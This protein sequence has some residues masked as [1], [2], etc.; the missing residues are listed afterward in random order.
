MY[1]Q[2]ARLQFLTHIHTDTSQHSIFEYL[3]LICQLGMK[4]LYAQVSV[5]HFSNV[6]F[7]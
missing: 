2:I 3:Q 1:K 6:N 7:K 4:I 5:P